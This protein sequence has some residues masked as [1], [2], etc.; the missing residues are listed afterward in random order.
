MYH[1]AIERA[2]SSCHLLHDRM[3]VRAFVQHALDAADLTG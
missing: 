3:T 1:A 2:A